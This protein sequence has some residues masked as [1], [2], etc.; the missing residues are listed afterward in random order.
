MILKSFSEHPKSSQLATQAT[1]PNL[2]DQQSLPDL[3]CGR[4]SER[5]RLSKCTPRQH[6]TNGPT[7]P[8]RTQVFLTIEAAPNKFTTRSL[9]KKRCN[10][11]LGDHM[12]FQTAHP[13]TKVLDPL[14]SWYRHEPPCLLHLRCSPRKFAVGE[15]ARIVWARDN[16]LFCFRAIF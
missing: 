12:F 14:S 2:H 16:H 13:A 10:D 7:P 5:S 3:W 1:L 8:V 9:A 11:Q 15:V 6:G 4:F